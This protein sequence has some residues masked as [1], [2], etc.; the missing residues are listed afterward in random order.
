M[1]PLAF[2]LLLGLIGLAPVLGG[3]PNAKAQRDD[4]TAIQGKWSITKVEIPDADEA[5]AEK[6]NELVQKIQVT[7]K[8]DRISARL[9]GESK[10]LNV[11]F[12]YDMEETPK[13]VTFT[14]TDEDGDPKPGGDKIRAIY[15]LDGNTAVVAMGVGKD[16]A[17]PRAFKPSKEKGNE[18]VVFYL[19]KAK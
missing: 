8:G 16:A 12:T 13:Q 11:R 19:K 17:R 6:L 1:R 7:V 4:E 14:E 18:V 10:T 15:K 5:T 2:L 3:E 9:P